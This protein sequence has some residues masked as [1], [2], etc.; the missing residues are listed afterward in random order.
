MY[1]FEET[2]RVRYDCGD[3]GTAQRFHQRLRPLHVLSGGKLE[4]T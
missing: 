2:I 3:M 1:E 4:E